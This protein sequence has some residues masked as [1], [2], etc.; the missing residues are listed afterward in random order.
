[1]HRMVILQPLEGLG[2]EITQSLAQGMQYIFQHEACSM[3][4]LAQG[5]VI[6]Y[7]ASSQ[8]VERM[9][10]KNL[11]TRCENKEDRRLSEICLTEEGKKLVEEIRLRRIAGISRILSKMDQPARKSLVND[12]ETFITAAIGDEESAAQTCSRCA[13]DHLAGCIVREV[14]KRTTVQPHGA[15]DT[16]GENERSV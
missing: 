14:Y 3:R 11:A 13:R 2:S 5:L 8:M 16:G 6:S 10:K 15:T 12:I 9:V 1:M 7:S 4:D